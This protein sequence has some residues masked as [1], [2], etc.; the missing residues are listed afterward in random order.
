VSGGRERPRR[1][2]MSRTAGE[3]VHSLALAS[4]A[5]CLS[6]AQAADAPRSAYD[7]LSIEQQA[8]IDSG[9]QVFFTKKL[10]SSP[11]PAASVY[12]Y[13]DATPEEA[14]AVF[15]DYERH[16]TFVPKLK[17]SKISRVIDP[18]TV[19]VDFKLSVPIVK[20]ERYTTR[21]VL[22]TYDGGTSYR[23][24]WTLVRASSTKATVGH[25]RFEPYHNER[26]GKHGTLMVYYN[27]VTPGSGLA[28][29]GFIKGKGMKQMREAAKAIKRQIEAEHASDPALLA[30]QLTALR[31]ALAP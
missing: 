4:L 2:E 24:D 11:W 12:Q 10:D 27:F 26:L 20:D 17:Q 8:V 6:L 28:G 9:G 21:H 13:V 29:L 5:Y 30:R 25:V 16:A 23:V 7:E 3:A 22:S 19:E 31:T 18:R 15:T 1:R 14:A